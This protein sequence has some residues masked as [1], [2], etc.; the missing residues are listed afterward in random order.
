[1]IY[2]DLSTVDAL[3]LFDILTYHSHVGCPD[4]VAAEGGGMYS[5]RWD[6]GRLSIIKLERFGLG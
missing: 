2:G 4:R 1:V 3:R 6:D 5:K